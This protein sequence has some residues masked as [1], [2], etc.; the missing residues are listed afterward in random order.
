MKHYMIPIMESSKV[1]KTKLWW[2]ASVLFASERDWEE[3]EETLQVVVMFHILIGIWVTQVY[4]FV[5]S[6]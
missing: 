6:H 1:G 3:P 5:K 2:K 4:T